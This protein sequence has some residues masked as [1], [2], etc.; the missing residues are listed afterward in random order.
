[1]EW[2][3]DKGEKVILAVNN[4]STLIN[5]TDNNIALWRGG[6]TISTTYEINKQL[7]RKKWQY[8]NKNEELHIH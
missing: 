8:K 6:G 3:I 7:I 4:P 2:L 1:M 5:N